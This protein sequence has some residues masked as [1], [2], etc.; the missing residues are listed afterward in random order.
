MNDVFAVAKTL[1]G[2]E[3]FASAVASGHEASLD[4]RLS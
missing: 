2:L 3:Q 1:L 4:I